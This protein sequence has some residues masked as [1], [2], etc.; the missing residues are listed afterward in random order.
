MNWIAK[1]YMDFF[2]VLV[3]LL[4]AV[5]VL[6]LCITVFLPGFLLISIIVK[7]LKV[8]GL[9]RSIR[10][11]R[12]IVSFLRVIPVGK[13][14]RNITRR[15]GVV[16]EQPFAISLYEV[17][18]V[19]FIGMNTFEISTVLRS[20]PYNEHGERGTEEA[21]WKRKGFEVECWFESGACYD[22][23]FFSSDEQGR[24]TRI[25]RT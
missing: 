8:A 23:I 22:C 13:A 20:R 5:V 14:W 2:E 12:R 4:N 10:A 18:P 21:H 1:G 16:T 25:S 11:K 15:R 3:Y 17:E 24:R 7:I 6:F 9:A 19:C